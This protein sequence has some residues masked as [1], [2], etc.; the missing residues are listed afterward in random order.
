VKLVEKTSRNPQSVVDPRRASDVPWLP[1]YR[2]SQACDE[3]RL[4]TRALGSAARA[5]ARGSG[6]ARR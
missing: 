1:A 4:V 2:G 6:P 3:A 5:L